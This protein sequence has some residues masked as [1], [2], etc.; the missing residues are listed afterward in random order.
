MQAQITLID[1]PLF[2]AVTPE[3]SVWVCMC[4]CVCV[5]VYVWVCEY[6]CVYVWVCEY[7][8][9]CGCV[10]VCEYVRE[11]THAH[12]F[13]CGGEKWIITI[14]LLL[15]VT[16][17][18]SFDPSYLSTHSFTVYPTGVEKLWMDKEG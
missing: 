10:R 13:K 5:S 9:V 2:K 14:I 11:C 1:L 6:V 18:I 12:V 4:E 15:C 3:V 16:F 17:D 7:V 8:C